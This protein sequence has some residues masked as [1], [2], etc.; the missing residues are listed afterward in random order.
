MIPEDDRRVAPVGEPAPPWMVN[1]ADLMTE[2]VCFFVILYALSAALNKDMQ[3]AQQDVQEMIKEG[4]MSGQVQMDKEGMRITMEEQSQVAF[5][6]SG[7]A[8]LTDQMRVQ[9]GKLAPVLLKLSEKHDIVVE[10]HTD[11]IPIATRLYASNWELSSA[12]ATSVVK[13]LLAD[14]FQ[15]K[16]L[17]AVGYGENHPIVP[18]DSAVNRKKNRRVVFFI[19]NTPYPDTPATGPP[20]PVK[21]EG[22]PAGEAGEAAAEAP[23]EAAPVEPQ[24]VP[25]TP[26]QEGEIPQAAEPEAE[27]GQ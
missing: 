26:A 13:F 17:S 7:K 19:K 20:A 3:K 2:L 6:E 27:G 4:K 9:M 25:E 8:D 18:N 23:A 1:Y 12:R 16:R 24:A 21:K 22:A 5:F 10:G 15:A 11:D 14:K